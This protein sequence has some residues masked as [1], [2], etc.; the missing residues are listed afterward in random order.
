[1]IQLL[2]DCSCSR[3]RSAASA[4]HERYTGVRGILARLLERRRGRH[5]TSRESSSTLPTALRAVRRPRAVGVPGTP[6][7][8][9]A[10]P[11]FSRLDMPLVPAEQ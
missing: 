7:A 5:L 9:R 4:R 8:R 2:G 1:M 3:H 6:A 11:F 10:A